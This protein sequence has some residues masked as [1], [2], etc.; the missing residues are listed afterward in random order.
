VQHR[1]AVAG[2]VDFLRHRISLH[3]NAMKVGGNF[4]VGSLKSNKNRKVELPAF[5]ADALAETANGKSRDELL[6]ASASVATWG[7]RRPMIRGYR[8]RWTAARKRTRHSRGRRPTRCATPPVILRVRAEL[9]YAFIADSMP[10]MKAYPGS[11]P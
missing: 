9:G 4:A 6:W 11:T 7:H 1:E 2:D 10:A 5:V 8:A 3:T